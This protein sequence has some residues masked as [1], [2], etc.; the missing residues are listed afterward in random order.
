MIVTKPDY[1]EWVNRLQWTFFEASALC[2]GIEPLVFSLEAN[3]GELISGIEP[4]ETRNR[5]AV[6]YRELKS[7]A[8]LDEIT[9]QCCCALKID[10]KMRVVRVEN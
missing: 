1:S 5:F 6:F 3:T 2:A 10:Q 4:Y 8:E 7:A 9:Y